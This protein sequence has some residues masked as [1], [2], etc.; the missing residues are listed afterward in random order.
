MN[1]GGCTLTVISARKKIMIAEECSKIG[2]ANRKRLD[3]NANVFLD[4]P[5]GCECACRHERP[6]QWEKSYSCPKPERSEQ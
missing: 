4:Y 1:I 2:D 3:N 6:L 5:E